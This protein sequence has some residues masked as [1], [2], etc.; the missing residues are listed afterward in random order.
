M[1]D[2]RALICAGVLTVLTTA[3]CFALASWF[4]APKGGS[5]PGVSRSAPGP[6][7]GVGLPA[8]VIGGY[9]WYRRRSK[10]SKK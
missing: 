4:P 7:V 5:G 10:G 9:F 1:I 6:V 8:L 3:P 2:H